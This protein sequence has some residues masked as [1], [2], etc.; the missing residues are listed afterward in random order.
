MR[1]QDRAGENT[2]GQGGQDGAGQVG[3]EQEWAEQYRTG[4][5]STG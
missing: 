3:P 1:Q 4:Q 2:T 5:G